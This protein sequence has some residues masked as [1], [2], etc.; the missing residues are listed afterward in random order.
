MIEIRLKVNKGAVYTDVEKLTSYTGSKMEKGGVEGAYDRIR[1]TD[2][3]NEMLE[4]FWA[5]A[6]TLATGSL[7]HYI[8]CDDG[9]HPPTHGVELSDC[10]EAK[11]LLP[12]NFNK[13]LEKSIESSLHSYFVEF[14]CSE[15]FLIANKEEAGVYAGNAQQLMKDILNKLHSRIRPVR[16]NTY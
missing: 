5:E 16:R 14:I 4:R 6:C 1:T 12:D 11:L 9:Y 10:Y 7:K 2:S 13:H 3:A 15:W 8:M